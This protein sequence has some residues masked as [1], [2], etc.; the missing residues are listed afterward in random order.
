MSGRRTGA[1][2][3]FAT[4]LRNAKKY[5]EAARIFERIN[6]PVSVSWNYVVA[7]DF[8]TAR[9][10]TDRKLAQARAP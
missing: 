2:I 4:L 3:D 7:G 9:L 6:D 10:A 5:D 1:S 8:T